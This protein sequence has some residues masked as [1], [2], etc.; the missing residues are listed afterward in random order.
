MSVAARDRAEA[1][2]SVRA[3][4]SGR[5][6]GLRTALILLP[7]VAV[8]ELLLVR[9]FY[10]VGVYIP[11]DGVFGVVHRVA[12]QVGSFL[13][14]ASSLLAVIVVGW[15]A[16][17]AFQAGRRSTAMALGLALAGMATAL[18]AGDAVE[19]RLGVRLTFALAALA[20]IAPFLRESQDRVH[21]AAVTLVASAMGLAV[22]AGASAD[23]SA[24]AFAGT[25][26]VEDL[27][28]A[29]EAVAIIAAFALAWSWLRSSGPNPR[30][31]ITGALAGATLVAFRLA[32]GSLLGILVLWTAGMRLYLPVWVYGLGG[33]ARAGGGGGDGRGGGGGGPPPRPAGSART[34][35]GRSR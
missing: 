4:G 14:N 23:A 1:A 29:A 27:Q 32:N 3:E 19:V 24:A 16:A 20:L 22:A 11:K 9:T 7:I 10:R 21:R 12:T 2:P 31:L 18:V 15:F 6:E 28:L 17:R 8:G 30:A 13:L 25:V 35:T 5:G 34:R 33:A 26:G